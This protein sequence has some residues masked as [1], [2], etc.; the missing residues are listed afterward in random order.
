MDESHVTLPQVGGMYGGDYS[1]KKNLIDHGFRLPSAYDN[2]PLR[3]DEFQELIPQM[4]YVSATPGERELR[5]LAEITN[6]PVPEGLLHVPSGGG[7]RK[8]DIEKR[9]KRTFLAETME[10][11]DGVVQMEIRP[12]GLLDPCLLYTSPSPRDATLS[13]MPSSA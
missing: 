5:H 13:R 8:A 10:N 1:R 6:Q 2:R 9:K 11:I 7:A 4:L 12:T 3:I